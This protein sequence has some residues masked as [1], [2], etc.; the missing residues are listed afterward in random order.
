MD[1]GGQD[2]D[3]ES[4]E[5]DGGQTACL[6]EK[7]ADGAEDFADSGEGNYELGIRDLRRNHANEVGPHAVE[8]SH[9]SKG[10]HDGEARADGK[11]PVAA[12]QPGDGGGDGQDE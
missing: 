2:G 3:Q 11:G 4:Y 8:V 12:N 6:R 10:E 7:E 1:V 9:G 5:G